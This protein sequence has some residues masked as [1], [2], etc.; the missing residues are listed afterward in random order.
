[1]EATSQKKGQ[2]KKVAQVSIIHK[3]TSIKWWATMDSHSRFSRRVRCSAPHATAKL[4][5][6]RHHLYRSAAFRSSPLAPNWSQAPSSGRRN[7]SKLKPRTK[8][9]DFFQGHQLVSLLS[10]PRVFACFIVSQGT[11]L[12]V[13]TAGGFA[14]KGSQLKMPHR[15]SSLSIRLDN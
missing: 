13:N 7:R 5:C 9:S 14:Y 11:W 3:L 2:N 15:K 8:L 6:R 10:F 1:M 4:R 12:E